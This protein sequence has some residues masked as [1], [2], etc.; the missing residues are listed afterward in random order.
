MRASEQQFARATATA[1]QKQ[2]QF[3]EAAAV[4]TKA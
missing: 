1:L 4:R 2:G 3:A